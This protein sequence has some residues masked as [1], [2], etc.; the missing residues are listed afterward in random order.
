MQRIRRKVHIDKVA[1]KFSVIWER[2][3][4]ARLLSSRV[5][6]GDVEEQQE[7]FTTVF[8]SPLQSQQVSDKDLS[9]SMFAVHEDNLFSDNF[10][11]SMKKGLSIQPHTL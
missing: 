7:D 1:W 5:V 6:A 9:T 3:C 8:S 2:C 11:T 4:A 10:G